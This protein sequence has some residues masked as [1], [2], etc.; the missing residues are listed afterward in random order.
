MA[1]GFDFL[2]IGMMAGGGA[3]AAVGFFGKAASSI[4]PQ[5]GLSD[6]TLMFLGGASAMVGAGLVATSGSKSLF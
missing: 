5:V 1:N 3:V 6:A 2:G 4:V